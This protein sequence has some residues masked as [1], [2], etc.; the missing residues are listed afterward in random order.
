VVRKRYLQEQFGEDALE[1]I[2]S[3]EKEQITRRSLEEEARQESLGETTPSSRFWGRQRGWE[4]NVMEGQR[5]IRKV[6][7]AEGRKSQ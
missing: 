7:P 5:L 3:R 4:E 6:A 2:P 1:L